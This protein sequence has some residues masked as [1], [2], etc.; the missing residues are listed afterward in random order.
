MKQLKREAHI[1]KDKLSRALINSTTKLE[2]AQQELD[3]SQKAL[4]L[5]MIA[6][7]KLDNNFDLA[8]RLY[9]TG[10]DKRHSYEEELQ[11]LQTKVALWF[12]NFS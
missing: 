10:D 2:Q 4:E 11:D 6:Q 12:P 5:A 9:H 1:V 3:Q 8:L 7:D